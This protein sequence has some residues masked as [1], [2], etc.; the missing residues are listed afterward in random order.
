LV[1]VVV[2]A[3]DHQFATKRPPHNHWARAEV[4]SRMQCGPSLKHMKNTAII[5]LSALIVWLSVRVIELENFRYAT[6]IGFCSE[7]A[8][9]VGR[10]EC[11]KSK[12]TR[13]S[14]L[15]HLFYAL[16]DGV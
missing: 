9:L 6:M 16:A 2:R 4:Q 11:L 5:L 14:G 7:S 8:D 3:G 1:L 12:Q 13:T 10:Y 15:W